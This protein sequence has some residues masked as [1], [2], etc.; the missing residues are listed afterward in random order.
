VNSALSLRSSGRNPSGSAAS[1][2]LGA[3]FIGIPIMKYSSPAAAGETPP[4]V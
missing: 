3:R 2:P 4:R 1:A